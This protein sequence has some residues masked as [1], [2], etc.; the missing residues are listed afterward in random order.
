MSD[1]FKKA[2]ALFAELPGIG[3]RQAARIV[4]AILNWPPLEID[5][6]AEAVASLNHGIT[7]CQVCF[8]FSEEERCAICS[9]SQRDSSKICVVE[10]ITDLQSIEKTGFYRGH[11]HVLG[12]AINPVDGVL[13]RHLKIDSLVERVKY[14][15][16][17][18]S[19][20]RPADLEV[21]L[22]TNPTTFGDTT[23]MYIEELL[24]SM[25]IKTSRLAKGL[26]SG[27]YLEYA[28]SATLQ[29]AF[30]NRK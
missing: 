28:D 1:K 27:T 11:Y 29:N 20:G 26:S 16:E 22:A 7:F 24:E 17:M 19:N 21:I 10:R 5:K 6:F 12:G 14:Y 8:N 4:M 9:G 13:P 2:M 30:K 3:P 18:H 15:Q 23:A 25:N